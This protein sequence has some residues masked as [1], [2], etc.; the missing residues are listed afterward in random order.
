MNSYKLLKVVGASVLFAFSLPSSADRT[1]YDEGWTDSG[2]LQGP[3]RV[4]LGES[5]RFRTSVSLTEALYDDPG[6]EF[7]RSKG[8]YEE[9]VGSKSY[10]SISSKAYANINI[11]FGDSGSLGKSWV[12]ADEFSDAHP[13]IRQYCVDVDVQRHRP[14]MS[15]IE[16]TAAYVTGT[17][18]H[19]SVDISGAVDYQYSERG[20]RGPL[21]TVQY[22]C[23]DWT[24]WQTK[25]QNSVSSSYDFSLSCNFQVRAKVFDG[26]FSSTYRSKR[27]S[28]SDVDPGEETGSRSPA[29]LARCPL[30][31]EPYRSHCMRSNPVC[32]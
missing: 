23:D 31:L 17:T 10:S 26:Y 8:D 30:S 5:N 16:L 3:S 2:S 29:C 25:V 27:I 6:V 1:C 18:I 4:I 14:S 22:K 11:T 9:F 7:Y 15:S 20:S 13:Y 28:Y 12:R 32:H 19:A 24:G 21:Y